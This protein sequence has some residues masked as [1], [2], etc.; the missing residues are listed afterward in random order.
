MRRVSTLLEFMFF[1]RDFIVFFFSLI[2]DE[3][4]GVLLTREIE[5]GENM[6]GISLSLSFVL[7]EIYKAGA[8][9]SLCLSLA[10][11]R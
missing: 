5:N 11:R 6:R 7:I 4:V 10:F 3:A 9:L 2:N 8:S 1:S